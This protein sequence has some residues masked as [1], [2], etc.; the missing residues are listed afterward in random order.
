MSTAPI[1]LLHDTE[2]AYRLT[3]ALHVAAMSA[4][5]VPVYWLARRIGVPTWQALCCG[6]LT[7]A[8]PSLVL[9]SAMTAVATAYPSAR[10][11][12]VR[13]AALEGRAAEIR[14]DFIALAG[15]PSLAGIQYII[16]PVAFVIAAAMLKG[17]ALSPGAWRY[18]V[19][20]R[21][22]S[23][24]LLR[25]CSPGLPRRSGTTTASPRSVSMRV[26]RSLGRR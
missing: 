4:A 1:W 26:L 5:A 2:S 12:A 20:S 10:A 6:A 24:A 13:V 3:Q 19:V 9:N 14:S 16:I 18:G 7:V 8:V 21:F 15:R 22:S 11:L 25:W 17:A 23:S